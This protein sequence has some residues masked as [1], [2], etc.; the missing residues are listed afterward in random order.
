MSDLDRLATPGSTWSNSEP[1]W[2][3]PDNRSEGRPN[4]VVVL[5]DDVGFAQLGCYGWI[6]LPMMVSDTIT[7]QLPLCALQQG[8]RY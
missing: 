6:V 8:H 7:S 3:E 5:L 2:P 4:V 1:E